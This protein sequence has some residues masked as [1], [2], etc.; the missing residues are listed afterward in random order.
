MPSAQRVLGGHRIGDEIAQRDEAARELRGTIDQADRVDA[1][2]L[3][4]DGV[5]HQNVVVAQRG[6]T[7]S[8]FVEIEAPAD[9]VQDRL[10]VDDAG[11]GDAGEVDAA[12][13]LAGDAS[14]KRGLQLLVRRGLRLGGGGRGGGQREGDA[15]EEQGLF[16][17]SNPITN[18]LN[19][20]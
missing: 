16:H 9:P 14:G 20:A 19:R 12:R 13:R 10:A 8:R 18:R 5:G 11:R 2:Q 15:D 7:R 3:R 6:R 4:S 1:A 17:T